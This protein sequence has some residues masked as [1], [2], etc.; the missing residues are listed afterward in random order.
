M[1]E[2]LR[3]LLNRLEQVSTDH[4]ELYDTECRERMGN[5]VMDGF[6]RNKSDFV[7]GDDF[8]LHAA[9]A[10]LA[11][12]EALAE[13]ITQANSQAAELGITDFHERLAAFQ[14]SDVESDEEGSVYDD[15]FGH[16]APDAFDSTGNVIG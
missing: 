6:V 4:E 9:V 5:A 7:L 11:I 10:N 14:N 16:S 2:L 12:K 15:F 3:Q 8:G 13:Y 1:E